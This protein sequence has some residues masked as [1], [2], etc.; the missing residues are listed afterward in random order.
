VAF[1]VVALI[2][3]VASFYA[4]SSPDG[5]EFV[6]GQLGFLDAA[7][8]HASNGSPLAGYGV[9]GVV[10]PRLST[11]LAGL[12]GVLVVLVVALVVGLVLRRRKGRAI[13]ANGRE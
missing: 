10:D 13:E 7:A 5:L 3:A 6:A 12:A 8:P 1:V 2:A 4:S 9:A 11:G